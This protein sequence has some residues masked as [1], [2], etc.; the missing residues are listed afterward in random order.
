MDINVIPVG[1]LQVNCTILSDN[2]EAILFDPGD[3]FG[4]IKNY[5]DEKNLKPIKILNT[6]AHFDHIGAV[7]KIRE[8]YKIPFYLHKDDEELLKM[9][10]QTSMMVGFPI[11]EVPEID[12][13]LKEG[14]VF[15]LGE[16][17]IRV[18]ETPG[19]TLGGVCFYIDRLKLLIAGDTLFRESVG[20]TDFPYA[21]HDMLISSIKN[22]LMKLDDEVQVITGHG[23]FTTIEHEKKYNPFL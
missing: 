6:H 11:A 16:L 23:E 14:D 15:E 22:K 4:T 9:A 13:F 5:L 12:S 10:P 7:Q 1:P 3:D 18:I 20:R 2:N 8:F 21:D 17:E 19:H